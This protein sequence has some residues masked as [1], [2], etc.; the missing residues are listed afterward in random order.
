MTSCH[1][2]DKLPG[3]TSGILYLRL[4]SPH[5]HDW[6]IML[7][8]V[9]RPIFKEGGII[10][11]AWILDCKVAENSSIHLFLISDW[12]YTLTNCLK[13]LASWL[14]PNGGLYPGTVSQNN[15]S[16]LYAVLLGYSTA[17]MR[18]ITKTNSNEVFHSL[19]HSCFFNSSLMN[20]K[21]ISS[22]FTYTYVFLPCWYLYKAIWTFSFFKWKKCN[23][24]SHAVKSS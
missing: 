16:I 17:A 11:W 9:R 15:P 8:E 21:V 18:N 19:C 3:T 12:G 6:L 2:G 22:A 5:A 10:S 13:L 4:A 1:L 14:F 7:T 23:T 24:K 20:T